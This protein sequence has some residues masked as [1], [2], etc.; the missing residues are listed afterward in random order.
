LIEL[1]GT[2]PSLTPEQ[3]AAVDQAIGREGY[4]RVDDYVVLKAEAYDRLRMVVDEGL[5]MS[6]VGALVE[7]AMSEEDAGD[8]LLE[9]YQSYRP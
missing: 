9:S 7:A 8:P 1:E 3:R 6:Q 4:A 5:D 2:M